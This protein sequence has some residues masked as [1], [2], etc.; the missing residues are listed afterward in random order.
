[1][2]ASSYSWYNYV[3]CLFNDFF[4]HCYISTFVIYRYWYLRLSARVCGIF[5]FFVPNLFLLVVLPTDN[6][7]KFD[8]KQIIQAN[9]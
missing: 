5:A 2:K 1:M 6:F 7:S 9:Y 8:E 4:K 3:I